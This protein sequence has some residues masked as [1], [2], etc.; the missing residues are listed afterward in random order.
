[1]PMLR[2]LI[3]FMAGIALVLKT[4]FEPGFQV[5]IL[6]GIIC[7]L[8][9]FL[10]K[11]F[12]FYASRWV[13]YV[14]VFLFF[15]FAGA[16]LAGHKLN[17]VKPVQ[18]PDDALL[19]AEIQSQPKESENA[20]RADINVQ[21][22]KYKDAWYSGDGRAQVYFQKDSMAAEIQP[23]MLISFKPDFDSISN[24]GNPAEFDYAKYMTYHMIASSTYLESGSWKVID[25]TETGSLRHYM[26]DLRNHLLDVYRQAGLDGD[27]FAVAAAL[28]LG[29]KDKLHDKLRHAYSA[30]GAMHVLAVSGLHVGI[31]YMVLFS[32]L[33]PLRKKKK[34]VYVQVLIIVAAIWFYAM[35]T[36]LSPSVTRAAIM[37]SFI[38]VGTLFKQHINI[39]NIL[40]ASAFVTMA[41]NP[42]VLTEL[43]FWLS[44]LAVLSIVTFYKPIYEL[45]RVKQPVLDK[46]WALVTVSIAAQIGTAPLTIFYFNQFSNYFILTNIMVI[47]VVTIIVYAAMLVFVVSHIIPVLAIYAGKALAFMVG[48]LNDVVFFIEKLPG[49]VSENLYISP[50]QMLLLYCTILMGSIM[51]MKGKRQYAWVVMG[52]II[53]FL[54]IDIVRNV[55]SVENNKFLVYNLNNYSAVNCIVGSDNVLF[56][57]IPEQENTLLDKQLSGYWLSEGVQK[58][59][60]VNLNKTGSR[61]MFTNLFSIDNPYVFMKDLFIGFKDLRVLIIRD[62]RYTNVRGKNPIELDYLILSSDAGIDMSSITSLFRFE[63]LILDSSFPWY[64]RQDLK[65]ELAKHNIP[66]HDVVEDGAFIVDL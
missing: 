32:L 20:F 16:F 43:G 30:S 18:I 5:L 66:V 47:P 51:F 4:G 38:S 23:G 15:F 44:Y 65:K 24:S 40:A 62:D 17:N 27:E 9:L 39:N 37:F 56:T 14:F 28:S 31:I 3:P 54:S 49:S 26:L 60:I 2:L 57:D 58:E 33:S 11:R 63:K 46:L 55:K 41:F 50:V 8:Y 36:G 19:L 7:V 6:S 59:K 21:A 25:Q 12:P 10:E 53:V 29:Y 22:Y 34:L 45:V 52:L 64:K 1:M 35:L 48:L 42:F 13:T 61:Y